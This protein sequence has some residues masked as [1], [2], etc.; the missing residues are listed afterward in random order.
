MPYRSSASK[1]GLGLTFL[2]WAVWVGIAVL[3]AIRAWGWVDDILKLNHNAV[4]AAYHWVFDDLP[5]LYLFLGCFA[6]VA[7]FIFKGFRFWLS[8]VTALSIVSFV[9][10]KA[11]QWYVTEFEHGLLAVRDV[12]IRSPKI[13]Q[14]VRILHI[15]DLEAASVGAHEIKALEK[16]ASLKADLVLFTGDLIEL[17]EGDD[18]LELWDELLPHLNKI[19]APLGFFGVYGDG[20]SLLYR[21]PVSTKST[22]DLL[23]VAPAYIKAG[24][25]KISIKGLSLYQ[26]RIE[27]ITEHRIED[28][29][30]SIHENV[31]SIVVGHGPD[32]IP[33]VQDNPIDLCLAGHTHGGQV[34]IPFFGSLVINSSIP[35]EW[36]KGF[37]EVGKTRIN[38]SAGLGSDRFKGMPVVRFGCPTEMTLI[39]LLP[40]EE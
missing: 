2:C 11:L 6:G 15:S 7:A 10:L 28:W 27:G 30:N 20:D 5:P 17:Q 33:S 22:M 4:S 35:K 13:T 21:I 19:E 39:E 23:G 31:F 8:W 32:Y 1:I 38:I 25:T 24:D 12:R 37:R 34:N 40:V 36:V 18:P 3:G 26:S 29:L 9:S 16:A 14:K